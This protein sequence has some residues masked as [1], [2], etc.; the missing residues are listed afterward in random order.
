MK[1]V[2]QKCGL[3]PTQVKRVLDECM[4]LVLKRSDQGLRILVPPDLM[5]AFK[6][7]RTPAPARPRGLPTSSRRSWRRKYLIINN[8]IKKAPVNE[9]ET[10]APAEDSRLNPFSESLSV[11]PP[12]P[13]P[14]ELD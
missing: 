8:K 13:S 9:R 12:P 6:N 2:G 10:A 4:V 11:N 7:K 5:S 1:I 3:A 14:I